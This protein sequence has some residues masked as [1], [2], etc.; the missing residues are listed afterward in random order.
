LPALRETIGQDLSNYVPVDRPTS[1]PPAPPS[2]DLQPGY[3]PYI[4]CPLPP[5]WQTT[6]DSL[7][8][9]YQNNLVPQVRLFNPPN[10]VSGSGTTIINNSA[11]SSS[12]GGSSSTTSLAITN[13]SV[14]T[15]AIIAG[16]KFAGSFTLSK[17]FELLT[18]TA[19]SPCRIQLYGTLAAQSADS[20]RPLDVSPPAGTTQNIICDVVLDT[21]PLIWSFQ[22]REG[23]NADN[24]VSS[25]IYL[26]VTNLDAITDVI[27]L[28]V[29]YIPIVS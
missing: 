19:S 20:Y 14:R 10:I 8:Q 29:A 13:T 11:V 21:A 16:N 24:P 3:N 25:T 22:N 18:I 26:T 12:S 1:I 15:P 2:K 7:R 23:A 27:T 9:F 4:R 6:P 5:I 17:A 28:T